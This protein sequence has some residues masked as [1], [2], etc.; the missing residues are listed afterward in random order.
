[1]VSS[2]RRLIDEQIEEECD[3]APEM[4]DDLEMQLSIRKPKF[5]A[6]SPDICD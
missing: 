5:P 4:I 3:Y 1:M 6:A 2:R